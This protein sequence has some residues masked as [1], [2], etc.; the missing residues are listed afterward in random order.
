MLK[1]REFKLEVSTTPIE[2]IKAFRRIASSNGWSLQSH[3]GSRLVDRFAIIMPM[4][5]NARTLG[6]EILDGPLKGLEMHSWAETKGSAG[7]INVSSWI[8]PGGEGNEEAR[9]LIRNWAQ[10]LPR[11]PWKW[12]F[13]ERSRI[14]YLLPVFRRSR[15]AFARLGLSSWEGQ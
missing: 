7:A 6:L 1:R 9:E 3:E 11:C 10:K 14:G 8:I 15:K 13:G 5:Q 12:T 2:N 4:A